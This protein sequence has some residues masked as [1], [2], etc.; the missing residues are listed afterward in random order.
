MFCRNCG[1]KIDDTVN[2]CPQCGNCIETRQSEINKTLEDHDIQF[3]LKPKFHLLYKLSSNI[4]HLAPY[5]IVIITLVMNIFRLWVTTSTEI[6]IMIGS[7]FICS[8]VKL[9]FDKRQYDHLE[10]NFYNTKLEYKDGFFNY[11]EKTIKYQYVRE[12][13]V[14]QSILERLF[15]IGT[16]RIFTTASSSRGDYERNHS[17]MKGQNGIY[18]HCVDNV[19]EQYQ[20][21]KQMIDESR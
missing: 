21:V 11:E 18:I 9:I 20:I 8:F 14:S 1:T 6:N 7:I 12:I 16:I 19:Y 2:F 3:Q 17:S 13:T 10:Y 5:I 15:H 4:C